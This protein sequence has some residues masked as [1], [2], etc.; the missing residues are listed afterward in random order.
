[1]KGFLGGTY[2]DVKSVQA[3]NGGYRPVKSIQRFQGGTWTSLARCTVAISASV[4]SLAEGAS[5][6]YTAVPSIPSFV[7]S[8]E[9]WYKV[10]GGA[11]VQHGPLGASFA[12]TAWGPGAWQWKVVA[13]QYDGTRVESA[14]VDTTVTHMTLSMSISASSAQDGTVVTLTATA[15][16]PAL[17]SSYSWEYLPPGGGWTYWAGQD[18]ASP[19]KT[20][21]WTV[22]TPG[23]WQWRVRANKLYGGASTTSAPVPITVTAIPVATEVTAL[24]GGNAQTIQACLDAAYNSAHKKARLGGT[25]Y[26]G[27]PSSVRVPG[28]ITVDAN[29]ATFQNIQFFNDNRTNYGAR[30]DGGYNRAG[31]IVW[32][33]GAFDQWNSKSTAWSISHCPSFHLEGAHIWNTTTK[34]H[35]IEINSSGSAA[36]GGD[37]RNMADSDFKIKI[38]GCTFSGMDQTPRDTGYD[39]AVHFDY[40]WDGATAAGT[41]PDGTVCHNI[42][43]RGCHFRRW[44]TYPYPTS[45]GNHKYSVGDPGLSQL[46]SHIRIDGNHFDQVGACSNPGSDTIMSATM[47]SRGTVH[48]IA[49][50]EVQVKANHFNHNVRGF[51]FESRSNVPQTQHSI[52]VHD[53]TFTA[54]GHMKNHAG[55]WVSKNYPWLDTDVNDNTGGRISGFYVW[56][57]KFTATVGAAQATWLIRCNDVDTLQ[58]NANNFWG[59][60]GNANYTGKDGNRIHGS[61]AAPSGTVSNY[62]CRDNTWS[63]SADGAGRVVSNS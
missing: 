46:H 24:S 3:Y 11:W 50:R 7:E 18:T 55:G 38:I 48:L 61:E 16:A 63:A 15:G 34:G 20:K 56:G 33:G 19:A 58:V 6:T 12:W 29:A 27:N 60:I 4:A 43:I 14:P 13:I 53:N 41:Y 52:F 45:I 42:L 47:A 36:Y 21:S 59:L 37:V 32:Y 57:N 1:M 22:N 23:A 10:P 31:G 9:W 54:N 8:Y 40:A 25:F 28:G 51:A 26:G 5:V 44:R 62:Q 2:S 49:F 17:V 35:G 30:G 39:E